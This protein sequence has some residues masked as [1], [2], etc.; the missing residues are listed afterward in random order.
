MA[1]R[2]HPGTAYGEGVAIFHSLIATEETLIS[3][4]WQYEDSLALFVLPDGRFLAAP[5]S[6]ALVLVPGKAATAMAFS[7]S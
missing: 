7:A 3:A 4:P 5:S 6:R 2:A 1:S